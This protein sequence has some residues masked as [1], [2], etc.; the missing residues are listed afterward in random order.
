MISPVRLR[1]LCTHCV[2]FE[3]LRWIKTADLAAG[4]SPPGGSQAR[5]TTDEAEV[6]H[7]HRVVGRYQKRLFRQPSS[8]VVRFMRHSI[9]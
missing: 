8:T 3:R 7:F 1:E 4:R 9:R 2:Q 5:P 6:A